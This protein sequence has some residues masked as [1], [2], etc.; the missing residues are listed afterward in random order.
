MSRKYL[1]KKFIDNDG[2]KWD[3]KIE[4]RRYLELIDDDEISNIEKQV[5]FEILPKNKAILDK[6]AERAVNYT[7]DFMYIQNETLVIEEIKSNFTRKDRAYVLRKKMFKYIYLNENDKEFK[8]LHEKFND[9][10]FKDAKFME[11]V[12]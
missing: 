1:S 2:N 7:C 3:S 5:Q 11:V 9:L 4:Y 6:R 10:K 8:K 12:K